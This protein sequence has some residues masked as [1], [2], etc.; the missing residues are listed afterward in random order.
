MLTQVLLNLA[1][2]ARDAMPAGG[3]LVI[4]A[5]IVERDT[6]RWAQLCV[7]DQ[8]SGISDEVLA[9]V[10]E[11]FFTTKQVG[12]GSGLGL[13]TVYGIVRQHGGEIEVETE[14]GQGTCFEI[15]LPIDDADTSG[16]RAQTRPTLVKGKGETVLLVEDEPAVRALVRTVLTQYGYTVLTAETGARA[17][18]LWTAHTAEIDLLLTDVVLPGGLDGVELAVLLRHDRPELGILLT[19]GYSDDTKSLTRYGFLAK[20]QNPTKPRSGARP[21]LDAETQTDSQ[22]F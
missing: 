2:N 11:P 8:G 12:R 21:G 13:A 9:H 14:I 15:V 17:I 6:R 19:S 18:E 22:T 20:P 5:A 10:F 7:R 3:Q 1:V 4:S 16:V